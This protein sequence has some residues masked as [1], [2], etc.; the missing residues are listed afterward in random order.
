M[1]ERARRGNTACRPMCRRIVEV[2]SGNRLAISSRAD[3]LAARMGIRDLLPRARADRL[4]EPQVDAG[5]GNGRDARR[6]EA[7]RWQS[8]GGALSRPPPITCAL[9][10]LLNGGDLDGVRLLGPKNGRAHDADHLPRMSPSAICTCSRD[11]RPSPEWAMASGSFRGTDGGGARADAGSSDLFL[12][13]SSGASFWIDP[14]EQLIAVRDAGC[15]R[16]LFHYSY[17]APA[18]LR[19]PIRARGRAIA[20]AVFRRRHGPAKQSRA[21]T[22]SRSGLLRRRSSQ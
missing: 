17:C 21:P 5:T 14:Q 4:A 19:H 11:G 7:A 10:M 6:E 1:F 18:G 22:R 2:V 13:R 16:P 12:G 3:H 15:A 9:Q 8:G 20:E